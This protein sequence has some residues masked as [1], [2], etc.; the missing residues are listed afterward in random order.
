MAITKTRAKKFFIGIKDDRFDDRRQS[1]IL[2][3][4]TEGNDLYINQYGKIFTE[5]EIGSFDIVKRRFG[6]ENQ[7]VL[8]F[9]PIDRRVNEYSYSFISYDI[10]QNILDYSTYDFG[11]TVSIATTY[12][13][14]SSNSSKTLYTIPNNFSSAKV[15][16]EISSPTGNN[17]EY[18]EINLVKDNS[19]VYFNDFGK[20][21]ISSNSTLSE[22]GIGEY[23]VSSSGSGTNLIFS[24]NASETL[25]YNVVTVSLANTSFN[26][27]ATRELRYGKVESVNVSI[28]STSNPQPVAI[29]TYSTNYN[30]NYF[31][32]QI[33]DTTNNQIELAEVVTL[34]NDIESTLI[35]YGNVFSNTSLGSFDV[36]TSSVTELLFTPIAN[37]NVNLTILKHSI[38]YVEFLSFPV[39]INLKNAELTTGVNRSTSNTNIAFKKDFDLTHKLSPIFERRFDGSLE[40][41]SETLSGVDLTRN[42]IYLP[43]HYFVSGE[44]V[45]YRAEPFY[46][47]K[48]LSPQA[49]STSGIGNSTV[50]VSSTSGLKITDYFGSTYIPISSINGNTVSLASTLPYQVNSGSTV[51]FYRLMDYSESQGPTES[52]ISIG[53]TYI[54]GIGITTKLSGNL[55]V[56]KQDDRFIGLCT[57]PL[58]ALKSSPN[59]IDFTS[60]GIGNNHYITSDN[61]N[62]RCIILVDNVIQTPVVSTATTASLISQIEVQ[63]TTLHFSNI[64]SFFSGDIIKIGSEIMK[65]SSVGVSSEKFIEVERSVLGTNVGVHSS[66]SLITKL[67]GNY[68]IIGSKIYFAEAPY[69]PIYDNVS[70]DILIRSTFQ[71]RVFLR[72]GVPNSNEETYQKNYIF[73]DV[74]SEFDSASKNFQL[75]TNTQSISGFS[76][77]NS[78]ILVNNLFQIPEDDYNLSENS[79][80]TFVNFTG[81]ATS[82]SYDPN[83]ASVPRG[84]IIVSVGSSSGFGYQPLVSAGGS[85]VV[86][87]AGTIQSISVGSSGSGY[88]E[89]LQPFIRVGVQTLS[90][91]IPNIEFI[92]T[93]A[94]SNGHIVSIAI[95]NPGTGYTSSNP[96]QVVFDDPLSYSNLNLIHTPSSSGIGSQAK[97]DIVVGQG[98]SVIDFTITN[99]GYSYN[100]GDILTVESGGISGIPTDTSKT[101]S[102]FTIKV[103]R[104]YTDNFGGWS[105]GQL[106]KLD[107]IDELFDGDRK[108]FPISYAGNRFAI[109]SKSGLDVTSLLLIFVND[110]LQEPEKAYTVNSGSLITFTEAPKSGEKCRILFYRGTPDIDVVDVD[111][112]ETIETGDTLQIIG[113]KDKFIENKRVV[114]DII[115]P[116]TVETN[117]YNSFGITDDQ[118]LL[119]PVSW[120]KQKNDIVVD[121]KDVYKS[122]LSYEPNISPISNIIQSVGIGSTQ[123]FVDSIKTIFDPKNENVSNNIIKKIQIIDNSNLV[124]AIA[125]AVVSSA[126]TITSVPISNGGFGYKTVPSVSIQSPIGIGLSG[127]ATLTASISSGSVNSISVTSAG[128]GYTRS[129]PPLVAIDTPIANEEVIDNTS[130]FGDFGIITGISTGSVGFAST[131]LIFDLY[132]P[133]DSYLRNINVTNPTITESEIKENYYFKVSN[134]NVGS[135]VTSLRKDGSIIGVGTIG[136]DNIYQVISVSSASTGV[137]GGGVRQVSRVTVSVKN[138]NGLSGLAHSEYYGDYSWGVINVSSIKNSYEVNSSNGVVGLNSTPL[139]RRYNY[140][141]YTNYNNT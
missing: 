99:Y 12:S 56:Y 118:E 34:N 113:E 117:T 1:S 17:Y 80:Q 89:A 110:V 70:G 82:V 26:E 75:K 104:T 19:E 102:D 7:G 60:V 9:A 90:S 101:F 43:Q 33:A 119:R 38:S 31:I 41:N 87:S 139:V 48:V 35:E 103:E 125:T 76:T 133:Q 84:G 134:S 130:Y 124:S 106:Q 44:K 52:S 105:I 138:N 107:D 36:T 53:S 140:L 73:D 14:I 40:Y 20:I 72:S 46:Y 39:S 71:G 69:G 55:Y 94:V 2:T 91:G 5:D 3:V 18:N 54:S 11:N 16:V 111:I 77:S 123:I 42:L 65:I 8:E 115:L 64:K 122:R 92:G 62:A 114:T 120:C 25:N 22:N 4:L 24:S 137:Y 50:Q 15:L 88:R 132:I 127:K 29:S 121:G 28:A 96:P 93:A 83:N 109:I 37:I 57:S 47:L 45:S 98:S 58:D 131:A 112:L 126:G 27:V 78:I 79:S 100:D 129:N 95:T 49:T 51:D 68:N 13:S 97:I 141:R 6:T 128:F 59:L 23:N 81:S 21:T 116:D 108:T 85:A 30:L 32:V 61:P 74:S 10:K 67:K 136:I 86:S 135:G 63:D 66:N